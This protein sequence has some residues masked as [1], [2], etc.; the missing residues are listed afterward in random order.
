[1]SARG[2]ATINIVYGDYDAI[3]SAVADYVDPYNE[4]T[5]T[6]IFLNEVNTPDIDRIVAADPNAKWAFVCDRDCEAYNE[7]WLY[8]N[9]VVTLGMHI[10]E[11][12]VVSI[13]ELANPQRSP[14]TDRWIRAVNT[15][16]SPS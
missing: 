13:L 7:M 9:G 6:T 2:S 8:E 16:Y 4:A 5:P 1:M 12:P 15:F 11:E 3:L 14:S 10:Q